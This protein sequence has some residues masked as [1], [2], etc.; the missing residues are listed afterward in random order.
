MVA[1][2]TPGIPLEQ[3]RRGYSTGTAVLQAILPAHRGPT[4]TVPVTLDDEGTQ[5]QNGVDAKVAVRRQLGRRPETD[6]GHRPRLSHCA[7][8]AAFLDRR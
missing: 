7:C 2:L 6:P 5:H 4:T 1:Q 8:R 3:A